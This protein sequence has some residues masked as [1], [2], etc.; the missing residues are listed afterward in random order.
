MCKKFPVRR[1]A[2]IL[3]QKP[4]ASVIFSH[5]LFSKNISLVVTKLWCKK[6]ENE[7]K[8]VLKLRLL[9]KSVFFSFLHCLS[10]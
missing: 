3:G 6:T 9:I 5:E 10:P 2:V 8:K 7:G 1:V 4:W